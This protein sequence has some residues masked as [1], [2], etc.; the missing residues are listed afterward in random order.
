M[1]FAS[2]RVPENPRVPRLVELTKGGELIKL[3]PSFH[4]HEGKRPALWLNK[5]R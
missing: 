5:M 4:S 1:R 3:D 2:A